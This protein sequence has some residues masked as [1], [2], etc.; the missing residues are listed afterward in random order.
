MKTGKPTPGVCNKTY[1]TNSEKISLTPN[2][3]SI[4][5]ECSVVGKNKTSP[6]GIKCLVGKTACEEVVC[7]GTLH[8]DYCRSGGTSINHKITC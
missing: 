2:E 5:A 8:A 7:R 6:A 1:T 4:P 3:V